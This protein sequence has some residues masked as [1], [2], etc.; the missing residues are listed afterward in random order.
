MELV[1]WGFVVVLMFTWFVVDK[2]SIGVGASCNTRLSVRVNRQKQV[3]Y[4][5]TINK[6]ARGLPLNVLRG[7]I[8][9]DLDEVVYNSVDVF[10]CVF[11]MEIY[12][13][14][15]ETPGRWKSISKEHGL[16]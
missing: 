3:D 10:Y 1:L 15:M 9:T 4:E 16:P 6:P 7:E 5:A 2:Q 14:S 8:K 12:G 11:S 13:D